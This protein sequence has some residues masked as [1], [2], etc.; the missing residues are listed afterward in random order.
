MCNNKLRTLHKVIPEL[1]I[2]QITQVKT[3]LQYVKPVY[4]KKT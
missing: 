1:I 4:T 3:E 2:L